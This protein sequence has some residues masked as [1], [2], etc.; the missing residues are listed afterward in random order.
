MIK[1]HKNFLGGNISV[2]D[3]SD[4]LVTLE[5]ELCDTEGDWFY[6]AFCVEGAENQTIT[7]QFRQENR[8]GYYG[9]AVSHDL[10]NWH[11]LDSADGESFTYHF[12]ATESKVYFAHH[13][14]YHPNRFFDFAK[15]NGLT[16][17]KLCKGRK[18]SDVPCVR[19]GTGEKSIILTAR[20]HACES[21]GNY[22]LEG[23]L[24]QM[25]KDP[26][27]NATVFCVPFVDYDGVLDGDQGKRRAPY[28][29]NCDYGAGMPSIYPESA[30]IREYAEKN[31]CHYLFDFHSPWHKGKE[32]DNCFIVQHS[33]EKVDRLNRFGEIWEQAITEQSLQYHHSD[34]TGALFCKG[35]QGIRSN[36]G[37]THAN[38]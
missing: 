34:D 3:Q 32:H 22:V 24:E 36:G 18:G 25:L 26:V 35:G 17:T 8:V 38:D 5:N 21:T 11:W 13:I 6:W 33:K 15:K 29:H 28:D 23:V 10:E 16:V 7:F 19:F 27:P 1:I 4:T 12:G 20:H 9:P 2:I 31:G 14:L 30:T 37:I